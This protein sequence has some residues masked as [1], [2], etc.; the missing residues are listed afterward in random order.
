VRCRCARRLTPLDRLGLTLQLM[1]D[2]ESLDRYADAIKASTSGKGKS[3]LASLDQCARSVGTVSTLTCLWHTQ[4]PSASKAKRVDIPCDT[5]TLVCRWFH[6]VLGA[7]VRRRD[8]LYITKAELTKLV[9]WKL[10]RGKWRP[11]LLK[12]AEEQDDS[13]VRAASQT[14]FKQAGAALASH[15][16]LH[17]I[18]RAASCHLALARVPQCLLHL[19]ASWVGELKKGVRVSCCR[20]RCTAKSSANTAH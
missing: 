8:H 19:T 15:Q 14:A 9:Q 20:E 4:T 2:Q 5:R 7:E 17:C 6:E 13:V 11:R 16:S 12:F 10:T 18:S 3:E 1:I